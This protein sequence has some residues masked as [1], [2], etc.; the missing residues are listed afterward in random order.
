VLSVSAACAAI[1]TENRKTTV[2]GKVL[3]K[4]LC[5]IIILVVSWP[6]T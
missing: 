2:Q 1:I 4:I 3:T 5:N 6:K